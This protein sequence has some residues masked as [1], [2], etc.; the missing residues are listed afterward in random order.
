MNIKE[1]KDRCVEYYICEWDEGGINMTPPMSRVRL[2]YP[3]QSI[4]KPLRND[5]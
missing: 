4:A 1:S 3:R 5:L 2:E